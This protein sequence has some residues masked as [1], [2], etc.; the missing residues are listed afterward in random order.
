[1][2]TVLGAYA[3]QDLPFEKLVEELRPA[4]DLS[5]N[6]LFQAV[7]A[8]QQ[9]EAVAPR[10]ELP[11]L[12]ACPV[13]SGEV[14]VRVDLEIHLWPEGRGLRGV[15]VVNRDLFDAATAARLVER[16]RAA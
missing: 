15:C 10:L 6:P 4:R 3:H 14:R 5:R 16:F 12:E 9:R 7:L 8:L 11:G 1:R 13:H 2:E